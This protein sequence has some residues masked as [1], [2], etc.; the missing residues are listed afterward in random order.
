M[1][2]LG[3]LILLISVAVSAVTPSF[4]PTLTNKKYS[5]VFA[6]R[7]ARPRQ[8]FNGE[9]LL[10][11][12]DSI[13]IETTALPT[14]A[15]KATI[16]VGMQPSKTYDGIETLVR[17]LPITSDHRVC[18][19]YENKIG[20]LDLRD[21]LIGV[22]SGITGIWKVST[23]KDNSGK[24]YV[25][26]LATTS[27]RQSVAVARKK[28]SVIPTAVSGGS[29]RGL[30][31]ACLYRVDSKTSS[32]ELLDEEAVSFVVS[33]GPTAGSM[34]FFADVTRSLTS[35]HNNMVISME[36]RIKNYIERRMAIGSSRLAVQIDS[37][38]AK[39]QNCAGKTDITVS[40]TDGIV[41]STAVST[42]K[43]GLYTQECIQHWLVTLPTFSNKIADLLL[44][45]N[46]KDQG[47]AAAT[48]TVFSVHAIVP[49]QDEQIKARKQQRSIVGA[50]SPTISAFVSAKNYKQP[51][52]LPTKL[53]RDN[54]QSVTEKIRLISGDLS[55]IDLS[56]DGQPGVHVK[57]ISAYLHTCR[58]PRENR[59]HN[60]TMV[61][62]GIPANSFARYAAGTLK[63]DDDDV[64]HLCFKPIFTISGEIYITWVTVDAEENR[65]AQQRVF[66][67]FNVIRYLPPPL[68]PPEEW[69][70]M[71]DIPCNGTIIIHPT[72]L[73]P[74][75]K[76]YDPA[77]GE[78]VSHGDKDIAGGI[79][80]FFLVILGLII[81]GGIIMVAYH[82]S[83]HW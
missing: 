32:I 70:L 66:P 42:Q 34:D 11:L 28:S 56:M 72:V 8:A 31:Y 77:V 40:A 10:P 62:D 50:M 63:I 59:C 43:R 54:D 18:D 46:V 37:A 68:P 60:L 24:N 80:V 15:I 69:C 44:T 64:T 26:T 41:C 4:R 78:C 53:S 76:V 61:E 47:N 22:G 51:V 67:Q 57:I 27:V 65:N 7:Q 74:P 73:C 23:Q 5:D 13:K 81:L 19:P 35:N 21:G 82:G 20:D 1:T 52:V 9:P 2:K 83:H 49:T 6:I 33:D 30:I 36:T 79:I 48:A 38:T 14:G 58:G 71:M 16:S 25:A 3:L 55:C 39:C 75:E 17:I 29:S 12:S 45:Y